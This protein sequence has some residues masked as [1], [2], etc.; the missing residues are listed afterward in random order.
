MNKDIVIKCLGADRPAIDRS[1]Q[2]GQTCEE[3]LRDCELGGVWLSLPNS[4]GFFAPD[5][6]VYKAVEN[7]DVLLATAPADVAIV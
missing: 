6:N 5:E 2:P 1:I 7:G 4:S 3:I